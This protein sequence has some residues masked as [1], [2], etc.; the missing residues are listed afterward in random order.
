MGIMIKGIFLGLN[1]LSFDQKFILTKD[2]KI[3]VLKHKTPIN[4][5]CH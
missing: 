5:N 3:R 2:R 4:F 1:F